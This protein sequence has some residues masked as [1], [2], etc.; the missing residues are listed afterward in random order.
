MKLFSW[1]KRKKKKPQAR[2]KEGFLTVSVKVDGY[3]V[4]V[5]Q[6]QEMSRLVDELTVKLEQL[7]EV[8]EPISVTH[9]HYNLHVNTGEAEKCQP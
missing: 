8:I 2:P 9:N 5:E 4:F 7:S 1:F 3:A 6:V